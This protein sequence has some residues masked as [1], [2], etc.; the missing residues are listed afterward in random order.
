MAA[1]MRELI[2]AMIEIAYCPKC[3]RA[4]HKGELEA[5]GGICKECSGGLTERELELRMRE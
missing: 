3:D 2:A 5:F 1:E 4:S